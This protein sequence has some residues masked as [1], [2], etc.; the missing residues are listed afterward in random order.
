MVGVGRAVGG[1]LDYSGLDGVEQLAATLIAPQKKFR[2][3][4]K[5]ARL[6]GF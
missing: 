2:T 4:I 1:R 3:R 5:S 6:A